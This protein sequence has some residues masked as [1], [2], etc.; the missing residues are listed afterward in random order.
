MKK[1]ILARAFIKARNENAYY[2][3]RQGSNCVKK[4]NEMILDPNKR[5]YQGYS[6]EGLSFLAQSRDKLLKAKDYVETFIMLQRDYA[7]RKETVQK[8]GNGTITRW[9]TL[10]LNAELPI[11]KDA[12]IMIGEILPEGG[13]FILIPRELQGLITWVNL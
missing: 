4:P 9:T 3:Y 7:V 1:E 11:H 8:R 13:L 6:L 2:V 12:R 10:T 5:I